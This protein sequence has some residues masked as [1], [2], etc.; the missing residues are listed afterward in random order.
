MSDSPNKILTAMLERLYSSLTSG[1]VM[2][3]RPHSSRQRIDVA[4]VARFDGS[5]P[6]ALLAKLLGTERAAKLVGNAAPSAS[7]TDSLDVET[8]RQGWDDQQ[9]ILSKL[10]TI[11]EDAK[12]YEQDTGAQVLFVGFPLLSV[13]P[14]ARRSG[15][16]GATK[17]IIAP[18]AFV[19]V[20]LAIKSQRPQT[21]SLSCAEDGADR[22]IA[23]TAL[24][25]WIEQQTGK[26]FEG[27]FVDEEGTQ[28]W[29]E[30]Q[31]LVARVC[32]A[33]EIPVPTDVGAS[34]EV[35]AVPKSED[36]QV[37]APRILSSA[38]LGLYPVS[39]QGL[40]R[41]LEALA[42]GEP[43]RG[44]LESF[45]R[46]GVGLGRSAATR[47]P[48]DIAGDRLVSQA[49]P[50]QARAVRLA[51]ESTG[52]VVH[53]PPGTGKSQTIANI[54]GDHLARGERV[55]FV[56]DKRTAL[57]VVH[58]RLGRLGMGSLCAV[59]HDAQRDQRELYKSIREQLDGL[60][61]AKTNPAAVAELRA[62]DAEL[63]KLH[64]ELT[65][66]HTAISRRSEDES[67]PSLHELAGEWFAI[68]VPEGMPAA[69][70]IHGIKTPEL[71]PLERHVREMLERSA[72]T[73]YPNNPWCEALGLGLQ[74]YLA[75]R[76]EHW[77]GLVDEI[78]RTARLADEAAR[79][80]I[81]AFDPK[82]DI[83][84]QGEARAALAERLA[85]LFEHDG[86]AVARWG[87]Q[88]ASAV[89]QVV[90]EL[91][92][93][94]PQIA[95]VENT[96]LDPE[97]AIVVRPATTGLGDLALWL[98]RVAAYLLIA[99]RWYRFFF[100]GRNRDARGVLQRF[101][102]ALTAA[103]AE[104][105]S[106]FLAG[107]RARRILQEFAGTTLRLGSGAPEPDTELTRAVRAHRDFFTILQELGAPGP[108]GATAA[109]IRTLLADRG[110]HA[111]LL[112]GL[113]ASRGR[114][115]AVVELERAL[116]SSGLF[117]PQWLAEM[118]ASIREGGTVLARIT[119]LEQR[120]GDIEGLLRI[121]RT[122]T[123]LPPAIASAAT[124]MAER[125]VP[126]D[127]AWS[128]MRRAVLAGQ[129]LLRQQQ[130]PELVEMDAERVRA[131]HDRYRALEDRKKALVRDLVQH[132]WV[133]RQRERLLATTGSRL[134]S[135]GAE[136]RRRLTLR[137]EHAMRVRQVVAA[138][139]EIADGDPLFDVR[140]VWMASPETVAQIFPRKPIFDVVVFDEASQCRLE[141]AL[142][143]LVRAR[144]V[145]IAGDPKQLP[146]TRFFES[147]LTRSQEDEQD[148]SEQG[149]FEDQQADVED[150]LGAALNL[151]IEQCY[152][153]VHYRSQN[154]DLI[155]FSNKSFYDKRLQA[156]PGHPRN[157]ARHPPIR[158]IRVNGVYEKRANPVEAR[159]V[160][161]IVRELLA[162]EAPPSIGIACFNL[163]QR[164]AIVAA[165]DEAAGTDA[166]FAGR[167]ASARTR[168]GAA[169]FE[170][171]FVKNLENVQGD[172]RDHMIISTTYGPD[173]KGRFYRR[174]GPLAMA[175][176]GRRL[177]VL[178]TRARQ[179]VHL[180]TSI[181]KEV[182]STI[183][184]VD[185]G[186]TPNGAWLLF[187]YLQY[188]EQLAADYAAERERLAGA[189][190]AARGTVVV[191]PSGCP[192]RLAEALAAR[193]GAAHGMSSDVHWGNDGFCVDVALHHPTRPED[194]TVGI[195]CD[196]ARYDKAED[197]V[198]WDLFRTAILQQQGWDFV[199]LWALHFFRDPATAIANVQKAA[200]AVAAREP[201]PA[202]VPMPVATQSQDLN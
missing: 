79:P 179:A 42:D 132:L 47:G 32:E 121:Q 50:C 168:Q 160:V 73:K 191:R 12:T 107:V 118:A 200:E 46:A 112:E 9:A 171:L 27:L 87:A 139:S 192:S 120:F 2:N 58:H 26:K 151:E 100:F 129:I 83:A 75:R 20:K 54:I 119:P 142:P 72:L 88:P 24:L 173:P 89:A 69:G 51:R 91:D 86:E 150:L 202:S 35:R 41:D 15:R 97:L 63:S 6:A 183:P 198:E 77:R 201:P 71:I 81:L 185:A 154:A 127:V 37:A 99:R 166:A 80:S 14:D 159:E 57:D 181:P 196:G 144:R 1:P 140:P 137:G 96:G 178:V 134:N 156:I 8:I 189:S 122:L 106:S 28:P 165:L 21:V 98:A 7:G 188:A 62:I 133:G 153:D 67:G 61:D 19:P 65:A 110:Q 10:R 155:E 17:R 36:E 176:G 101:G 95:T 23:N 25:A 93:V 182:Y 124:D 43:A 30:I 78:R 5:P 22:V 126:V 114:A 59:V 108:L 138:G 149:L 70:E 116:T 152:L 102:L 56:C 141:E 113:R 40:L 94:S 175:G 117:A 44:P 11:A 164:D 104:R 33:L 123:S 53:G 115:R 143:V 34:S 197:P 74:D 60:P 76:I 39:N 135:P 3:C 186:R 177:N 147:A 4:S 85:L 194:V 90:R 170:G 13:P 128:L 130:S 163:V 52:L 180:V 103:S 45:L 174:F 49:D 184:P 111:D 148:L 161:R 199:R 172:E 55:L 190:V 195:L 187:S 68:D 84:S 136:L 29:R 66:H 16:F 193:L 92:V 38:V 82:L 157:R 131:T 18:I 109:R 167:L 169:S 48:R 145:V 158:C 162:R 31:E 146:P 125:A 64:S 105:V